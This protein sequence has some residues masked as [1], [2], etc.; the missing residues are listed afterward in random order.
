[1]RWLVDAARLVVCLAVTLGV[2]Y[3]GSIFTRSSVE[4]WYQMLRKPP[5][6]PPGWVFGP[7]WTLLYI[8]MGFAAYLVARV[9]LRDSAVALGAYA[10]QLGL[11]LLWSALFFGMRQPLWGLV[12]IIFLWVKILLTMLLFFRLSHWAGWLM[13]PYL[14]W[15]TF[16]SYLNLAIWL[17]NRQPRYD[18]SP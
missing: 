13:A 16:A 3:A 14:V 17:M 15:V 2:G 12:D 1:M 4:S 8:M 5:L 11:N 18:T 10:L 7:V 6:T 9:G